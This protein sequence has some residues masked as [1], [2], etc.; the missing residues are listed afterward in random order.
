MLPT[1]SP[2]PAQQGQ[3][4]QVSQLLPGLLRLRLPADPPLGPR[5]QARQGLLLQHVR[6][7]LH[8][9]ECL[10]SLILPT[11]QAGKLR[12]REGM[13]LHQITMSGRARTSASQLCFWLP[14]AELPAAW[15]SQAWF[16]PGPGNTQGSG[17]GPGT[18]LSRARSGRGLS[19]GKLQPPLWP[20]GGTVARPGSTSPQ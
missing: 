17:G 12:P 18:L 14:W 4:L 16:P 11:Y 6:A 1:V 7:G 5:H 3:A 20:Q 9:G 2:A 13:G 10:G 8:L 15:L 19:T